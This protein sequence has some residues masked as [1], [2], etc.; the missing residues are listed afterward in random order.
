MENGS[1]SHFVPIIGK[2]KWGHEWV[3]ET[4]S[5][6]KGILGS[7]RRGKA[8]ILSRK[9]CMSFLQGPNKTS[10]FGVCPGSNGYVLACFIQAVFRSALQVYE[11]NLLFCISCACTMLRFGLVHIHGMYAC[12]KYKL[13]NS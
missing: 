8:R 5:P 11:S 6:E 13:C 4:V 9:S 3:V 7:M 2:R 12:I 10:H 1:N